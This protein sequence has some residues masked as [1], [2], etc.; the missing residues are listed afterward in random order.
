MGLLGKEE[1]LKKAVLEVKKINFK[2]GDYVFVR[3]MTGKERNTFEHSIMRQEKDSH[4]VMQLVQKL[5]NFRTKIAVCTLCDEEGE[6]LFTMADVEK[7]SA[8][9]SASMLE[10]IATVAQSINAI[11]PEVKEEIEKN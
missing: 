3:E 11:T 5:D 8:S 6:L 7:L 10:E 4:G 2:K 9:V 1:L